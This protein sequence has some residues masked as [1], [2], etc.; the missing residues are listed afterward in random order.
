[1]QKIMEEVKAKK[2]DNKNSEDTTSQEKTP[3]DIL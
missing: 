1:M 2:P 3:D